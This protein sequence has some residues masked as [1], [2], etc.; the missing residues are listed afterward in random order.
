MAQSNK[1]LEEISKKLEKLNQLD[2]IS[3]EINE[4]KSTF[5]NIE[6]KQKENEF[7]ISCN[8]GQIEQLVSVVEQLRS[9]VSHLQYSKIKNNIIINGVPFKSDESPSQIAIELFAFILE[10]NIDSA[11]ISSSRRMKLNNNSTPPLVVSMIDNKIKEKI[12][13]N[14]TKQKISATFQKKIKAHFGIT[15]NKH[16]INIAEEKTHLTNILFKEA[17]TKLKDNYKFIWVKYG[18]LNVR[19]SDSSPIIRIKNGRDLE[20]VVEKMKEQQNQLSASGN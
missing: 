14:W 13:K 12:T 19:E 2:T 16:F 10:S 6:K 5:I 15:D 3:A 17:K 7:Q 8:S 1:A 9:D 18:N 20:M 11:I 4:I